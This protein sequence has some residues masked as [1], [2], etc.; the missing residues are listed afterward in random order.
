MMVRVTCSSSWNISWIPTDS[1]MALDEYL[2][3]EIVHAYRHVIYGGLSRKSGERG[4][5]VSRGGRRARG[6]AFLTQRL[7]DGGA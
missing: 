7:V 6:R 5:L 1:A 4:G 3:I 2:V